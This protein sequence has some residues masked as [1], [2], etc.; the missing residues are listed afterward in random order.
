[1]Y[2][3]LPHDRVN[4][5]NDQIAPI[6]PGTQRRPPDPRAF[7]CRCVPATV[8][9]VSRPSDLRCVPGTSGTNANF[10]PH[11]TCDCP[12][13][14]NSERSSFWFTDVSQVHCAFWFTD[15]SQVHCAGAGPRARR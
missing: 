2:Q 5:L 8:A 11:R 13:V 9:G 1:M 6:H 14:P 15:V 4:V 3:T 10:Y 12:A 7:A